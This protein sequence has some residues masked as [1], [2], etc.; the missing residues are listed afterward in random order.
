LVKARGANLSA[1]SNYRAVFARRLRRLRIKN[2]FEH[3]RTLALKLGIEE[4]R[5]TRYE[6]GEVEP[7]IATI[8]AICRALHAEPN[9]LF[10]YSSNDTRPIFIVWTMV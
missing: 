10:G 2:G 5:Y 6:R 9:T 8:H 3:A 1:A 7:N 4:N